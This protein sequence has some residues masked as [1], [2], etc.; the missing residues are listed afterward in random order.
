MRAIIILILFTILMNCSK[1]K[2]QEGS[3]VYYIDQRFN[4]LLNETVIVR[5][6]TSKTYDNV[7]KSYVYDDYTIK[8]DSVVL[9]NRPWNVDC[10]RSIFHKVLALITIKNNNNKKD[11]MIFDYQQCF[12]LDYPIDVRFA[13]NFQYKTKRLFFIRFILPH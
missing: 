2:T 8:F 12:N 4:C 11:S 10:S 13:N 3:K 7:S 1:D 5:D 6:S 9:D